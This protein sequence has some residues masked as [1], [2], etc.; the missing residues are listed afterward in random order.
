MKDIS[1]Q[2]Q[3]ECPFL[4]DR[5]SLASPAPNVGF[6]VDLD[7]DELAEADANPPLLEDVTV[8]GE[9][10]VGGIVQKL[11]RW[12]I[13]VLPSLLPADLMV[14]LER[15]FQAV[16]RDRMKLSARF[17]V[18][19]L[20][21]AACVRFV[22]EK[23]DD[24]IYPAISGLFRSPVLRAISDAYLDGNPYQFNHQIFVHRTDE[25]S[26]P[27][28][29]A[30]HFDVTRMLKFWVY[31]SD[32]TMDNGAMRAVPG[33]HFYLSKQ[34]RRYSDNLV[35]KSKIPNVVDPA[36]FRAIP[37]T[38]PAG[39]LFVFDTDIAHGALPVM[40]GGQRR[41]VRAHCTEDVMAE[42]AKLRSMI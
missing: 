5:I 24:R 13:A 41:I 21:D 3:V 36:V 30:L 39:T 17:K 31:L 8:A 32:G 7:R 35:E 4:T 25:T 9:V 18:D 42:R 11:K 33:S 12:G 20:P 10:S 1:L 19:E 34:R 27:L 26:T 2:P 28:S 16:M 22:T 6:K 23:M 38:G 40:P 15:D 14:H 37:I 29:G